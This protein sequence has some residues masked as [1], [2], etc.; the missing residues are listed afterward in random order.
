[1]SA[2]VGVTS[3]WGVTDGGAGRE[4]EFWRYSQTSHTWIL[5]QPYGSAPFVTWTPQSVDQGN[6]SVI[7]WERPI[8]S[9][10]HYELWRS[11]VFSVMP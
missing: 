9:S 6:W 8:G 4:Y 5:M 7:V 2:R 3:S 1:V 11:A 10:A